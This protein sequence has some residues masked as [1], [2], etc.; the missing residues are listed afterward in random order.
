MTGEAR[1]YSWP[2]FEP[3]HE[4]SLQHG[5]RSER[6]IAPLAAEIEQHARTLPSWPSYLDAAEYGAAVTAWARAEAVVTLLWRWLADRAEQGLDE[7]LAEHATE[8]TEEMRGKGTTRRMTTGRRVASVLEQLRKWESAAA[9]HRAR[10]GLDPLSRAKL[11]KD[12]AITGAVAG[13]IERMSA[14][15]SEIL[16]RRAA[17]LGAGERT[18][19][20]AGG[21]NGDTQ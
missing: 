11:S 9:S 19:P 12:V 17:E 20:V 7:L 6:R 8:E 3:G 10:L 4:R 15:G 2:P 16:A 18:E 21:E 13:Q 5:A 14:M 1:G